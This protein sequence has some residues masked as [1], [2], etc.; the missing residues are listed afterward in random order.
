MADIKQTT[1]RQLLTRLTNAAENLERRTGNTVEITSILRQISESL[2]QINLDQQQ[3]IEASDTLK[4][5]TETFTTATEELSRRLGGIY[6][7]LKDILEQS[8]NPMAVDTGGDGHN[9]TEEPGD[10]LTTKEPKQSS[11][12]QLR[13]HLEKHRREQNENTD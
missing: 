8:R 12:E 6:Y 7:T 11:A 5:A 2:E 3:A 13:E 10:R 9:Y 1:L 4:E